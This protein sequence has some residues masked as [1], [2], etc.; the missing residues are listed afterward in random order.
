MAKLTL[1]DL[2]ALRAQLKKSLQRRDP[3][4]KEIQVIVGMGTCGIAAGGKD[5]F[6]AFLDEVEAHNLDSQVVVRQ[7][8]CMEHCSEEPTV[9]IV[10]P[11]ME[12]VLYGKVTPAVVKD[13]VQTHLIEKKLLDNLIVERLAAA[14]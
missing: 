9:E 14:Q 13:I 2:R 7:S 1:E 3:E 11:G 5:V 8:G 12:T 10:V 6:K 4:G